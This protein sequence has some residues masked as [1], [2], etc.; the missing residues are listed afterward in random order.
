MKI[1]VAGGP[2]Q[3]ICEAPDGQGGTWNRDGTIVFA[4]AVRGAL[5]R[6]SAAGG[7]PVQ[8]TTLDRERQQLSHWWPQFLPDGRHFLY[9]ARGAQQ[10]RNGI[11]VSSLDGG[12]GRL[13]TNADSNVVCSSICG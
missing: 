12:A 1:D 7:T 8:A 9:L 2:A 11:F 3:P 13:V 5:Y 4:P 10:Q 6:V